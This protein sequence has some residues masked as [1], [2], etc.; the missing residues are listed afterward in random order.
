MR[1]YTSDLLQR[2]APRAITGGMYQAGKN[3]GLSDW[4]MTS[5]TASG[6]RGRSG[7]AARARAVSSSSVS[8]EGSSVSQLVWELVVHV[9]GHEGHSFVN[10]IR[11]KSIPSRA[12]QP[13]LTLSSFSVPV[14]LT[15]WEAPGRTSRPGPGD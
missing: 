12:K 9:A 3:S 7:S 8:S 2:A 6:P 5:G 10:D 11:H 15:Y 13:Q 1:R 14:A 4:C